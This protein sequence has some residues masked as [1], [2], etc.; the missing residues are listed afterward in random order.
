[1][2]HGVDEQPVHSLRH[3]HGRQLM[4]VI[5]V[6]G[7]TVAAL[8]LTL[9]FTHV[10]VLELQVATHFWSQSG[11]RDEHAAAQAGVRALKPAREDIVAHSHCEVINH[12]LEWWWWWCC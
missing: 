6:A 12:R 1:M 9:A 11:V 5:L 3:L 4:W 7:I 2:R 10:F 8:A